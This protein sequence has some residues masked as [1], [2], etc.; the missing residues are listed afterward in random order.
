[1][2]DQKDRIDIIVELNMSYFL[3][4]GGQPGNHL[5]LRVASGT[6]INRTPGDKSLD[7]KND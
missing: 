5:H 3:K 4:L 7:K 2:R 6:G 1:M